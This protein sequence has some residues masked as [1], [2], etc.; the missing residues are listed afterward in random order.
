MPSPHQTCRP[1]F[2]YSD[3]SYFPKLWPGALICC[4]EVETCSKTQPV[5]ASSGSD[6]PTSIMAWNA[7]PRHRKKS[8]NALRP[9]PSK[10]TSASQLP[11]RCSLSLSCLHSVVMQ[12]AWTLG[13]S[14]P[15]PAW[16]QPRPWPGHVLHLWHI[17]LLP[18]PDCTTR[19]NK[20]KTLSASVSASAVTSCQ[21][22]AGKH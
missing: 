14:W 21:V 17:L 11:V 5:N 15:G 10:R 20:A 1:V 18:L 7:N 2:R 16:I 9:Q 22:K 13:A 19:S 6:M 3:S 8:S 12:C 4:W